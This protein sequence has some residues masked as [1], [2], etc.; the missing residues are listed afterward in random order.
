MTRAPIDAPT[1]RRIVALLVVLF[2]LAVL[3]IC[4]EY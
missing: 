4:L 3:V 1:A 2:W